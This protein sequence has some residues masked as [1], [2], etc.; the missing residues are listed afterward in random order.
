MDFFDVQVEHKE[1]TSE[2]EAQG[3]V[4]SVVKVP[5]PAQAPRSEFAIW[6]ERNISDVLGRS[7]SGA[8]AA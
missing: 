3:N 8:V 4:S 7:Y 5:P 1:G 2:H 6:L